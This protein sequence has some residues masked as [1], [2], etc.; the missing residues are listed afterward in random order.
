M[1]SPIIHRL[2]PE[3]DARQ[4]AV[5]DHLEGPLLVIAAPGTGKTAPS[6]G[7]LSTCCCK[8]W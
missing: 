3:L 7:A 1:I 5:V 4:R 8:A 6:C 2:Q